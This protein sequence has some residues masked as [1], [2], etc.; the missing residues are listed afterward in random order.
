[1]STVSAATLLRTVVVVEHA[2]YANPERADAPCRWAVGILKRDLK[3]N[4]SSDQLKAPPELVDACTVTYNE[5]VI[6]ESR[7]KDQYIFF[8]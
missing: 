5:R 4:K 3:E 1:V 8:C 2:A 7:D 6:A